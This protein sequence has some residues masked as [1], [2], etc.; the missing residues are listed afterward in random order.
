ME[1]CSWLEKAVN[2]GQRE[3]ETAGNGTQQKRYFNLYFIVNVISRICLY[4]SEQA[5]RSLRFLSAW[6]LP[7]YQ[8]AASII[9]TWPAA[10][11]FGLLGQHSLIFFY[12]W[13]RNCECY[14]M[15]YFV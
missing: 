6:S 7:Y 13:K 11:I 10:S 15:Y 14:K 5:D 12:M 3:K 2:S 1:K 8:S 4:I 9:G